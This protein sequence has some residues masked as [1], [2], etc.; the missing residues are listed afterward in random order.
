[1]RERCRTDEQNDADDEQSRAQH[2]RD[3]PGTGSDDRRRPIGNDLAHCLTDLG[4]IETHHQDRI[5]AHHRGVFNQA[6]DR[7]TARLL[8]QQGIFV[9]LAADDRAQPGHDVATEAAAPDDDAKALTL[10]LGYLVAGD[11]FGGNNQHDVLRSVGA[12]EAWPN[13]LSRVGKTTQQAVS[14]LMIS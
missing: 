14:V 7:V 11:V 2:P 6:I 10:D 13:R 9:D 8:E 4:R 1:M 3:H 5:G 12:L